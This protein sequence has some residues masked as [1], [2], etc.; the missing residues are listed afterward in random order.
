MRSLCFVPPC[1]TLGLNPGRSSDEHKKWVQCKVTFSRSKRGS[2]SKLNS[3]KL[4]LVVSSAN[5]KI[6]SPTFSEKDLKASDKN[7]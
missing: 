3:E 5:I 1:F 4:R 7:D 6:D 2:S